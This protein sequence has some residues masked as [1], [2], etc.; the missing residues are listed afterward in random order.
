[1]S[2]TD[3]RVTRLND[4]QWNGLPVNSNREASWMYGLMVATRSKSSSLI[5]W[6]MHDENSG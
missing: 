1:M 5:F 4:G 2:T 6:G 3:T